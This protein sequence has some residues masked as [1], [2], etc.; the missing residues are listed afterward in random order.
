MTGWT[1]RSK[2]KVF[3]WKRDGTSHGTRRLVRMYSL[4]VQSQNVATGGIIMQRRK[5]RPGVCHA[6]S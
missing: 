1:S 4:H 6:G 2:P 3:R 5:Q